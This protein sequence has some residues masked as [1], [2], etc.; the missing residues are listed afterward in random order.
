MI[1]FL[2]VTHKRIPKNRIWIVIPLV[3]IGIVALWF[4]TKDESTKKKITEADMSISQII[5]YGGRGALGKEICKYFKG[6]GVYVI[7]MDLADN[8]DAN[9]SIVLPRDGTIAQQEAAALQGMQPIT[10]QADAIYCVAGGWAGGN[11]AD[12]KFVTTTDNMIKQSLWS[13]AIAVSVATKYLKPDGVLVLSGSQTTLK[14]GVGSIGYSVAK[15]AVHHLTKCVGLPNSGLLATTLAIL[16]VTL[17]TESNRAASPGADTST[18]TPLPV[19]V[20]ILEQ[21][22]LNKSNRPPNGSLVQLF[23]AKGK[24]TLVPI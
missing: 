11:V 23:T 15:Q 21:W 18:W 24:T 6:K 10:K 14:E 17:D 22:T 13:S 16:P 20:Q 3:L 2:L 19:V 7:S 1:V 5:V 12:S 8:P 9:L 4:A